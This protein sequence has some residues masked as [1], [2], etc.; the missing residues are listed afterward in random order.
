[1]IYGISGLQKSTVSRLV[2]HRVVLSPS[3]VKNAQ[4]NALKSR[5]VCSSPH[6]Y[7]HQIFLLVFQLLRR[8]GADVTDA[9]R[10][11]SK[12]KNAITFLTSSK[13][14]LSLV[15]EISGLSN[16]VVVLEDTF[17]AASE[18]GLLFNQPGA[19]TWK[20]TVEGGWTSMSWLIRRSQNH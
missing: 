1:M 14:A 9:L 7:T 10:S 13:N 16:D 11:L 20:S 6:L 4:R 18:N 15:D 5:L 17:V 3:K 19:P 8:S 12:R 2:I